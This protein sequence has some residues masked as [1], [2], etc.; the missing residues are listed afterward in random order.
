M[1]VKVRFF[2]RMEL[3]NF[4]A[5]SS[6]GLSAAPDLLLLIFPGMEIAEQKLFG[7]C[8]RPK[9]TPKGR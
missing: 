5:Q 4:T 3:T 2:I 6:N 9:A 8:N 7:F 1:T